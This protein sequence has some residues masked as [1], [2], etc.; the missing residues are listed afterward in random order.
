MENVKNSLREAMEELFKMIDDMPEKP[1]TNS[2]PKPKEK[3]EAK[4]QPDPTRLVTIEYSDKHMDKTQVVGMND[5]SPERLGYAT[6]AMSRALAMSVAKATGLDVSTVYD[7]IMD[8]I[9]DQLESSI[10]KKIFNF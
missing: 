9:I 1:K 6:L 3:V 10:F 7:K 8:L 2:E 5:M 4:A